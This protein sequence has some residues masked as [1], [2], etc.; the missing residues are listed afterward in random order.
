MMNFCDVSG[1]QDK[2]Q[3]SKKLEM[4]QTTVRQRHRQIVTDAIKKPKSCKCKRVQPQN[5]K[6]NDGP[7]VIL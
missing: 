1:E 2:Q 5:I 6:G 7:S 3:E 4:E